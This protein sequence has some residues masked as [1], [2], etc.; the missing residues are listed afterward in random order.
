MTAI[1]EHGYT[2]IGVNLNVAIDELAQSYTP[3]V[4][5][6]V[7]FQIKETY[8]VIVAGGEL[9]PVVALALALVNVEW[10]GYSPQSLGLEEV[11]DKIRPR[12]LIELRLEQVLYLFSIVCHSFI[13]MSLM[14]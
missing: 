14:L 5:G 13:Q 6:A 9:A 2:S 11:D 8:F 10:L 12:R 7:H 3:L 4:D 1:V